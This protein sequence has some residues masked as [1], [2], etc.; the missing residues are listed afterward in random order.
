MA[1]QS[2]KLDVQKTLP[3]GHFNICKSG[4]GNQHRLVMIDDDIKYTDTISW[5]KQ[6]MTDEVIVMKILNALFTRQERSSTTQ[7]GTFSSL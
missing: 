7:L 3:F 5:T 6:D 2:N 4:R 1:L